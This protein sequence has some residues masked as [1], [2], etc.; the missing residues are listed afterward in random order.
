MDNERVA[1]GMLGM[2]DLLFRTLLCNL[3]RKEDGNGVC[4][5][6]LFVI[7]TFGGALFSSHPKISRSDLGI[8]ETFIDKNANNWG[9]NQQKARREEA[10][11]K[12]A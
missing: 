4:F 1:N 12:K 3:N 8:A 2:L 7:D 5:S 11:R 9:F 6:G 10:R